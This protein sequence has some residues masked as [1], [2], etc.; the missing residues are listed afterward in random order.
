MIN[1]GFFCRLISSDQYVVMMDVIVGHLS[2]T[3]STTCSRL[4]VELS[5]IQPLVLNSLPTFLYHFKTRRTSAAHDR[6][7]LSV[8]KCQYAC[9]VCVSLPRLLIT[10]GVMQ[11]DIDS[12]E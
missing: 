6:I 2:W 1:V 4:E 7:A 5:L 9:C 11:C 8:C 10:S 12:C 3:I